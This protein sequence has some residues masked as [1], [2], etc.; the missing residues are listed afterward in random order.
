MSLTRGTTRRVEA[1]RPSTSRDNRY[2]S[3]PNT[4]ESF[5]SPHVPQHS[6]QPGSGTQNNHS[7][8]IDSLDPLL[9]N[10]E[11][12]I[13]EQEEAEST[14]Q[15]SRPR[16]SR[17]LTGPCSGRRASQDAVSTTA[18]PTSAR[19]ATPSA[20]GGT[21]GPQGSSTSGGVPAAHQ[22]LSQLEEGAYRPSRA[23]QG[24]LC[25]PPSSSCGVT[26]SNSYMPSQRA[27]SPCSICLDTPR[28]FS[29]LPPTAHCTHVSTICSSCL[30]QHISH[31][32]LTRGS[33]TLTCPDPGCRQT[34]T[35]ADVLRG[36]KHNK[37]CLDRYETLL[38]RWTLHQ[39]PKFVWCK[40]PTCGWGQLHESGTAAPIVTCQVCRTRS[41]SIHD[42][43]WHTGLTCEQYTA[44]TRR[45]GEERASQSY[46]EQHAKRCPNTSCRRP[47]IKVDGCDHMTCRRPA[48]C[49]HEFCWVCL[50][51]YRLIRRD[52]N[53]R[54]NPTCRYYVTVP[55]SGA[56]RTYGATERPQQV[57]RAEPEENRAPSNAAEWFG[58]FLGLVIIGVCCWLVY[59]IVCFFIWM[60]KELS[61]WNVTM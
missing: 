24:P 18:P 6:T 23:P 10:L 43:P 8:H 36:A 35:Y 12:C 49:G 25:Q 3:R 33:T 41:C 16:L 53:H 58:A 40:N 59:L 5:Y 57:Q 52:G 2:S 61:R 50:A 37:A 7:M 4:Q 45:Q 13:L 1:V 31:A 60:A 29:E 42:V 27:G 32:V 56:P 47:I 54:H 46:I 55:V 22:R 34:M 26:R 20:Q 21:G 9:L 39:D 48:G 15:P 44:Q 38:L 17:H 30:E 28:E 14:A 19:G 51:D 11:A